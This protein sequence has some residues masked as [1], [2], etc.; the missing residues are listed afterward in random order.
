MMQEFAVTGNVCSSLLF[1]SLYHSGGFSFP[2]LIL[3]Q[4]K[5][6]AQQEQMMQEYKA[7]QYRCYSEEDILFRFLPRSQEDLDL[8]KSCNLSS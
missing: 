1:L 7:N 4:S 3:L 5:Q 2:V 6:Y 8:Q